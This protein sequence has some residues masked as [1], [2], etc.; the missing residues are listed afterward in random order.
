MDLRRVRAWDWLAGIAGAVLIAS[1]FLHWYGS[2]T[3]WQS[4]TVI[5]VILLIVGLFGITIVAVNATQ[6]TMAIPQA[7]AGLSV[8]PAL[9]AV[10]LTVYRAA[11]PPTAGVTREA[12]VWVAL[13]AALVLLLACIRVM[14]DQ[15]SP[16]AAMPRIE[17][18]P[19]PEAK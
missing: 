3:G 10:V 12:G 7:A 9:V 8:L 16:R 13:G 15:R 18:L 1:L 2:K 4:F 11:S 14:N 5:D 17:A 19:A 6:R